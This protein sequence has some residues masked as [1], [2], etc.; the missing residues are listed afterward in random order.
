MSVDREDFSD[1][2]NWQTPQA[3]PDLCS[4]GIVA[5]DTETR[6]EGV[7]LKQSKRIRRAQRKKAKDQ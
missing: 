7:P 1:A 4:V 3:L 5:L 6:D 2:A